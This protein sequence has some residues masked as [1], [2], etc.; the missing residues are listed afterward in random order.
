MAH[1]TTSHSTLTRE[2]LIDLATQINGAREAS[3]ATDLTASTVYTSLTENLLQVLQI[4][5]GD[6]RTATDVYAY[7]LEDGYT[8]RAALELLKP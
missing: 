8:V 5:T 2:S 6:A 3:N 7:I 4:L 1:G